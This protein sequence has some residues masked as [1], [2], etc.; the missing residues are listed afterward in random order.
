MDPRSNTGEWKGGSGGPEEG[1]LGPIGMLFVPDSFGPAIAGSPSR[2]PGL[3]SGSW[4]Y[5][6]Q[7][8][9]IS[10]ECKLTLEATESLNLEGRLSLSE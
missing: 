7:E 8:E 5:F 3:A 1:R 9:T 6:Q 10:R 4:I 2:L